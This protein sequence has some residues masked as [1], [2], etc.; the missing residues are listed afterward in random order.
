[1]VRSHQFALLALSHEGSLPGPRPSTTNS[2]VTSSPASVPASTRS[3]RHSL[4]TILFVL[5]FFPP[6]RREGCTISAVFRT[7]LRRPEILSPLFS[8][9]STL[10]AQN[11]PVAASSRSIPPP[12]V[13]FRKNMQTKNLKE[14]GLQSLC[15]QRTYVPKS[16]KQTRCPSPD[17]SKSGYAAAPLRRSRQLESVAP[18][19]LFSFALRNSFCARSLPVRSVQKYTHLLSFVSFKDRTHLTQI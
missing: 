1:M 10:F 5:I 4:F 11:T 19:F 17:S 7:F 18:F 8:T 6:E 16:Q 3:T 2:R 12:P 13:I 9:K 15:K 14:G